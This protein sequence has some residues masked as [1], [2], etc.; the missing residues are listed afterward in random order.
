MLMKNMKFLALGIAAILFAFCSPPK[1]PADVQVEEIKPAE[2][3]ALTPPMGWNSFDAYDCR[4]NEA[5]YRAI[6]DYMSENLLEFGWDYAI[7]DYIW[8]HPNPGSWDNPRRKGH[9]NIRYKSPGEPLYPENTNLDA[10]GRLIPSV[11]RENHCIPKIP[12]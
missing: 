12:I 4:I 9:P 5:E 2:K 1:A 11:E 7:I 8:W 6:V 10:F 3:V